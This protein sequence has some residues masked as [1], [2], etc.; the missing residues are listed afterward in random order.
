[1]RAF[2]ASLRSFSG[3]TSRRFM[4]ILVFLLFVCLP[5]FTTILFSS[6]Q[7]RCALCGTPEDGV[8]LVEDQLLRICQFL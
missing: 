2:L 4:P 3:V 7:C 6:K 5:R 1:M 8:L